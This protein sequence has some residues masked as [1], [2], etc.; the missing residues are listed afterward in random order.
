MHP[1]AVSQPFKVTPKITPTSL[2]PDPRR[3]RCGRLRWRHQSLQWRDALRTQQLAALPARGRLVDRQSTAE[4][5]R[6]ASACEPGRAADRYSPGRRPR[7]K[8]LPADGP[9]ESSTCFIVRQ[10]GHHSAPTSTTK[11]RPVSRWASWASV[12][13]LTGSGHQRNMQ[14]SR[15]DGGH[16]MT[17]CKEGWVQTTSAGVHAPCMNTQGVGEAARAVTQSG[18]LRGR[19]GPE[20]VA[21]S[22]AV[23]VLPTFHCSGDRIGVLVTSVGQSSRTV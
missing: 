2:A 10:A 17:S 1:L 23:G 22:I 8:A 7:R 14:K 3:D 5:I 19:S 6:R 20:D 13:G 11:G 21:N 12:V 16:G 9:G 15:D 4:S 18:R